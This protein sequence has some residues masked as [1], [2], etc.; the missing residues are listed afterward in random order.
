M[1]PTRQRRRRSR[2][3]G[4]G[5]LV[6]AGLL[7]ALLA[8]VAARHQTPLPVDTA[9]HTWMLA[10]RTRALTAVAVGLTTTGTGLPAYALAAV[11]GV[12]ATDRR[13]WSRGALTAVAG[14]AAG[15]LLRYAL[16]SWVRRP[17][18]PA[19]DWAWHAGG[20]ALPSGHTTT[21]ALVAGLLWVALT[22]RPSSA[23]AAARTA[24]VLWAAAVA[25]TRV[26]LGV[27]WPTDIAAG[28]LLATALIL[29]VQALRH[30]HRGQHDKAAPAVTRPGRP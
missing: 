19:A 3:A 17:R 14:L 12:L 28:W 27:H 20:P 24:A 18:P 2:A 15:Q 26:Y 22:N 10:H 9:L 6:A 30:Q 29:A 1:N 11:A 23:R 25:I 4:A 13:H 21:S 5:A 8:A 7:C 16:A